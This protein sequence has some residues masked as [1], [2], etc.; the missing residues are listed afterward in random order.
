[1]D[2]LQK[3]NLSVVGVFGVCLI[4]FQ[5]VTDCKAITVGIYDLSLMGRCLG[6]RA[7]PS[8]NR[9]IATFCVNLDQSQV[10]VCVPQVAVKTTE[11]E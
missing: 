4:E 8:T 5:P 7:I 1:M 6:Q 10:L 2:A 11:P 3:I 9:S